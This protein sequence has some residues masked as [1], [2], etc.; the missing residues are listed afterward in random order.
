M[1]LEVVRAFVRCLKAF[2]AEYYEDGILHITEV[3]LYLFV[4]RSGRV[5]SEVRELNR[6]LC[7]RCAQREYEKCRNCRIY[8]LINRIAGR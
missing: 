8:L 7:N 3:R 2:C 6:I 5:S 4:G 1:N